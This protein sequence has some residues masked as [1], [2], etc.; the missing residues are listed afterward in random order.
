MLCLDEESGNSWELTEE[1]VTPTWDVDHY[2]KHVYNPHRSPNAT[3]SITGDN[4]TVICP[5]CHNIVK[6]S[7][8]KDRYGRTYKL[9]DIKNNRLQ[10]FLLPHTG[11]KIQYCCFCNSIYP[12]YREP[13]SFFYGG[14]L[15]MYLALLGI[16]QF[17]DT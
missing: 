8:H 9:K 11:Q 15:D 16:I 10:S 1:E 7:Y 3:K 6:F 2:F 14:T 5:Y 12:E 13:Y 17:C 4:G